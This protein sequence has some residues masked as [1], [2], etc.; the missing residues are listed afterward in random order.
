[1]LCSWL[2]AAFV[3]A[4]CLPVSPMPALLL[5]KS[6]QTRVPPCQSLLRSLV[7]NSPNPLGRQVGHV[8]SAACNG[9]CVQPV[10]SRAVPHPA[11]QAANIQEALEAGARTLLVD[12]DTSAT[13]FM[14][15]DARMQVGMQGRLD[16]PPHAAGWACRP[17]GWPLGGGPPRTARRAAGLPAASGPSRSWHQLPGLHLPG[18][19]RI[20]AQCSQERLRNTMQG[21]C[22]LSSAHPSP[23]PMHNGVMPPMVACATTACSGQ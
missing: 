9:R 2:G 23:L 18:F 12:E 22:S 7:S 17:Q 4:A 14:I 16:W 3:P 20:P 21:F 5:C 1:M 15:R 10:A 8:L 13:N 19:S 6:Q 11:L